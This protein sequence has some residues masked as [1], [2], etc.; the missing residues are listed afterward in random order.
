MIH[1]SIILWKQL[2]DVFKKEIKILPDNNNVNMTLTL[3]WKPKIK[4]FDTIV[5]IPKLLY[6]PTYEIV[7]PDC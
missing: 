1:Y 7:F 5:F 6:P 3:R 4:S 2:I